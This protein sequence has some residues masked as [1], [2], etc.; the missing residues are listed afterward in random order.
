MTEPSV[1]HSLTLAT[2]PARRSTV[3]PGLARVW[4]SPL[5]S[6][7]LSR[8][9]LTRPRFAPPVRM[10]VCSGLSPAPPSRRGDGTRTK[11]CSGTDSDREVEG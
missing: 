6:K 8:N 9:V 1:G 7:P 10:P 3:W 2:S 11:I 5:A 4:R